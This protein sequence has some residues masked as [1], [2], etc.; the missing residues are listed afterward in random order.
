M[1]ILVYFNDIFNIMGDILKSE[2]S[3][4]SWPWPGP[5]FDGLRDLSEMPVQYGNEVSTYTKAKSLL[6]ENMTR[7]SEMISKSLLERVGPHKLISVDTPE[8][9]S[10]I[11][12]DF[13]SN[14]QLPKI[15]DF[16][17]LT[18]DGSL[19]PVDV[20]R[21]LETSRIEQIRTDTI[22]TLM[23]STTFRSLIE[24]RLYESQTMGGLLPR[25]G[26]FVTMKNQSN[27]NFWSEEMREKWK[28]WQQEAQK[29][30]KVH[31]E[32]PSPQQVIMLE[33]DWE[34]MLPLLPGW[35]IALDLLRLDHPDLDIQD[36]FAVIDEVG[37]S[38]RDINYYS[39]L[40]AACLSYSQNITSPLYKLVDSTDAQEYYTRVLSTSRNSGEIFNNLQEV[41]QMK[42]E[43]EHI[44][45]GLQYNQAPPFGN[46][47]A[48]LNV[49][50][51]DEFVPG[52]GEITVPK[53][54]VPVII[55]K[56]KERWED[57]QTSMIS[58]AYPE[59]DNWK[60]LRVDLTEDGE[61]NYAK[62]RT[63]YAS[64]LRETILELQSI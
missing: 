42:S 5:S 17:V 41:H 26:Y 24:S 2:K 35:E 1:N 11:S 52:E 12:S 45:S 23:Q 44:I 8:I 33:A 64:V 31:G 30:G 32:M 36:P 63:S 10:G 59:A 56:V 21:D 55:S 22:D 37:G 34:G 53:T 60:S 61:N 43:I 15:P 54:S 39:R 25:E 18:E 7:D 50:M 47:K 4:E 27:L 9:K 46:I 20:K 48:L 38:R 6:Q 58:K 49:K 57:I 16:V 29:Q 3:G 40:G 51:G 28:N 14:R 62:L 19:L 13:G